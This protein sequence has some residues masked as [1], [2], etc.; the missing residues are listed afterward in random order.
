MATFVGGIQEGPYTEW[1]RSG[2]LIAQG[3]YKAGTY[4]GPWKFWSAEGQLDTTRSGRYSK[5]ALIQ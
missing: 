4:E 3:D 1:G 5:G 2:Q